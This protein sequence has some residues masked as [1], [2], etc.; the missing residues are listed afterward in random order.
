MGRELNQ[1]PPQRR[2]NALT[3]T[4]QTKIVGCL[5]INVSVCLFSTEKYFSNCST[6]MAFRCRNPVL[7]IYF[8]G[9]AL[10]YLP[11]ILLFFGRGGRLF[12][13]TLPS[14][15]LIKASC[16]ICSKVYIFDSLSS[17]SFLNFLVAKLLYDY[18]CPSVCSLDQ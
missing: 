12:K 5:I 1:S 7:L 9:K 10:L 8:V 11:N 6:N 15:S 17:L 14:I 13:L 18:K 2:E 3:V 4:P 16:A